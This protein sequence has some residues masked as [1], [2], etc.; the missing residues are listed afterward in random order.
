MLFFRK[1]LAIGVND[2]ARGIEKNELA[3]CLLYSE[4]KPKIIVSHI[5]DLAK[6]KRIPILLVKSLKEDMV[7]CLGFSSLAIGF[8]VSEQLKLKLFC[9][10]IQNK[11]NLPSS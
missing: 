11:I 7:K 1:C 9:T 10:S 3:C 6:F 5:A 4:A 8:K 2:V